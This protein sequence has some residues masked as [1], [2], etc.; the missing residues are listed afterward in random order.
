[1]PRGY[2][3]HYFLHVD[4]VALNAG[5]LPDS[6]QAADT[7]GQV[8]AWPAASY[9]RSGQ[10]Q[11]A[12]G[13]HVGIGFRGDDV[14]WDIGLTGLGFPVTNLVGGLSRGGE[15]GDLR[16]RIEVARRPLT[17]SLLSYAG[18]RD[19]ITGRIWGGVVATGVAGRLSTDWRG[20]GASVSASYAL[21]TGQNVVRNTRLQ[22]R[23]ALDRDL[24][25]GRLG[26]VNAGLA[27]SYW[28]YGQDLSEFTWGHGGYYSPERYAAL[29]LP[30]EWTGRQGA[31][32]W[33]VRASVSASTSSSQSSAYFPGDPGLQAQAAGRLNEGPG[34]PTFAGGGSSG[35]GR[36]LRAGLEYRAS[37]NVSLGAQI[38]L[39]RS[40]YYAPTNVLVYLRYRFDPVLAAPDDRPRPV[41]PYSAF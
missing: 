10:L 7:F 1:M 13:T 31:F 36:S 34:G 41:Q 2:D 28:H 8:A 32:S 21:L 12:R 5:A 6:A 3:G 17:G 25:R 38:E 35:L 9:L 30:V 33:R 20:Y 11:S 40:A 15:A 29:A 18:A 14:Q 16:Y 22:L 23:G 26:V 4:R 24:Y 27:L 37:S 39:D 19:P